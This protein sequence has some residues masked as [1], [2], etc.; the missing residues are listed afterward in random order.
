MD[1]YDRLLKIVLT[2]DSSVGK[3]CM[4]SRFTD[5]DFNQG[6]QVSTICV[7]FK[8]KT[9][10]IDGSAIKLQMWDTSGQNRFRL[11]ASSYYRNAS[12]VFIVFDLGSR[13]SLLN[14]PKWYEETKQYTL[15]E[16]KMFM[17]GCKSD[18]KWEVNRDEIAAMSANYGMPWYICSAKND[19]GIRD[20]FIKAIN[21]SIDVQSLGQT[22]R[23]EQMEQEPKE[24]NR[25]RSCCICL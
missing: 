2:G 15:N 7:D 18:L 3:T 8:T 9:I 19:I 23:F 1:L 12:I 20:I 25:S 4:L 14:V 6:Q 5:G 24:R 16:T 21:E 13:A 10:D 22:G 17:I 11:M